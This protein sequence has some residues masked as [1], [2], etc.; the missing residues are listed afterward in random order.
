MKRKA[1]IFASI[2]GLIGVALGAFGAHGLKD[3]LMAN[4][5]IATFETAVSYQMYH[6]FA[7]FICGLL[8][9]DYPQKLINPA[10]T[11]FTAGILIFSGSLY[12]LSITGINWLGAITPIG[13]LF[14]IIG[15]TCL[16]ISFYT[17]KPEM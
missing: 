10:I 15:W 11:S 3:I 2:F 8:Y 1:L 5:R 6:T 16:L 4:G 17:K 9:A 14:F 7:L 12:I 13:G